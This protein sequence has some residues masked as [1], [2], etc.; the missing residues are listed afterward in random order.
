MKVVKA[1]IQLYVVYSCKCFK[2]EGKDGVIEIEVG[3]SDQKDKGILDA[4]T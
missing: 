4:S 3:K 2:W 1:C